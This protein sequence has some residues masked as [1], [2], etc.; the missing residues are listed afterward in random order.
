[1]S[2]T[3]DRRRSLQPLDP[4]KKKGNKTMIRFC[5]IALIS[6]YVTGCSE[7]PKIVEAKPIKVYPAGISKIE[8]VGSEFILTVTLKDMYK[9]QLLEGDRPLCMQWTDS[10]VPTPIGITLKS[11]KLTFGCVTEEFDTTNFIPKTD[12]S[13]FSESSLEVIFGNRKVNGINTP[14]IARLVPLTEKEKANIN[15]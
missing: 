6:I 12:F 5:L 8:K 15:K 1:L 2:A 4:N 13:D 7:Q 9:V 3:A 10:M 11:N 14:F